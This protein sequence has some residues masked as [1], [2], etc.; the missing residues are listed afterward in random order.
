[1]LTG[2][3]RQRP[4][5][6]GSAAPAR[7]RWVMRRGGRLSTMENWDAGIE[8]HQGSRGFTIRANPVR[9]AFWGFP[10]VAHHLR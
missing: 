4:G 6:A 2:W 10:A 8:C 7:G 9:L 3:L 1:M 5:K